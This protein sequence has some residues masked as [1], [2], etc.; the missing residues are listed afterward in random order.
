MIA[1]TIGIRGHR[2]ETIP[3]YYARPLG[4]GPFPG[5]LVIHHGLGL[6]EWSTEVARKFAEH[7][8]A[9][10]EPNLDHRAG[11]GDVEDVAARVR[12]MGWFPDDQVMGDLAS[13]IAFLRDQPLLNGRVGVIGFCSGGRY[14]YMAACRLE[15]LDA[16]VDCWGGSVVVDD[17]A[18]L[19]SARPVAPVD[20]TKDMR[21]PLLGIFGNEDPNPTPAHVDRTEAELKKHGKPYEFHR[22]DGIGHGFFAV[23]RPSYRPVQAMEAWA[24][25][26]EFLGKHLTAAKSK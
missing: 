12:A 22:Y 2:N 23:A 3:A 16:A 4:A 10:I 5:M 13:A 21:C 7:G 8:Y 20:L 11:E 26:F 14:T 17:P 25:V 1:E 15:G 6:D 9:A 24:T 18:Q 19:T